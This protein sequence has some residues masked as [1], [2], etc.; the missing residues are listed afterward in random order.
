MSVYFIRYG[1]D[2]PETYLSHHGIGPVTGFGVRLSCFMD[3]LK[4]NDGYL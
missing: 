1:R 3:L 4:I 2:F